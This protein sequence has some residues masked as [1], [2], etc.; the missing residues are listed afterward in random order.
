MAKPK[1]PQAQEYRNS[2]GQLVGTTYNGQYYQNNP[3]DNAQLKQAM[4]SGGAGG[5]QG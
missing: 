3:I 5:N 2:R 4:K 1:R